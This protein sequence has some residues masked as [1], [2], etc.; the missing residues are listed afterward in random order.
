MTSSTQLDSTL[1]I[2]QKAV[3]LEEQAQFIDMEGKKETFSSFMKRSLQQIFLEHEL[4]VAEELKKQYHHYPLMSLDHR[5]ELIKSTR[6]LIFELSSKKKKKAGLIIQSHKNN[7]SNEQPIWEID[8]KWVPG[9]GEKV[10]LVLR[11]LGINTILDLI[12]YWPREHLNFSQR[13]PIKD[14]KVGSDATI[15]GIVKKVNAF[16]SPKNPN[17]SIVSTI[18]GDGSGTISLNRFIAGRSSKFLIEQYKKQMPL[19]ALIMAS[20]KVQFDRQTRFQLTNFSVQTLDENDQKESES[21]LE[22]GRIVSIYALTEGINQSRLRK[23]IYKSIERHLDSMEESLPEK[24]LNQNNL[25]ELKESIKQMHF[26]DSESVL[27]KAK[28]RIAFEE[29]WLAQMPLA[30]K[31]WENEQSKVSREKRTLLIS[32]DGPIN[33]LLASLPFELTGAQNRV[34][35]EI[36]HDLTLEKPMNRLVQGDVGSG[37]TIIALLTMLVAVERGKQA[38]MMAPTEILAEQHYKKFQ[39]LLLQIGVRV[40]LLI[41]SQKAAERREILT[42]LANGQIQ[43]VVGTHALIQDG[44]GFADLGLVVIDEQHRF[45]VRQRDFLRRKG[46]S[47]PNPL[48]RGNKE[49]KSPLTLTGKGVG[50]EVTNQIVD[51]LHM[52]ATPIPRTLTLALYGN[53][54]LSEIDEMPPGRKPIK[55]KIVESGN[56]PSVHEFIKKQ[57]REGRQAY[58]VFPLIEESETLSAKAVTEEAQKLRAI[59]KDF[60]LGIIHGRLDTTEKDSVMERFRKNEINILVGTTVIEVGVDVPNA[61]IMVIENAERFGLAQLHQLRGRVGRG[62]EQSYCIL[63]GNTK[64]PLTQQRLQIMEQTENGFVIAQKDLE[65]RG[66][67]ELLGTRQSGISDFALACLMQQGH[68]LEKARQAANEYVNEDPELKKLPEGTKYKLELLKEKTDLIEGG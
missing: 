20:G 17:L 22:V 15:V 29:F 10:S 11:K 39:Q 62:S 64:N 26:P 33:N 28:D 9:V 38:A 24:I 59:Y 45:G 6:K 12:T 25:L 2:I 52:T 57:L 51:C 68:L 23:I 41:G 37:K 31:R 61:S 58:I 40:G 67:G 18:V 14:L 43:I 5:I 34:F 47:P 60:E 42:G 65:L 3:E 44:V 27:E 19:G 7:A 54:D 50:G 46:L 32:E 8:V 13:L 49:T 1:Q 53:L 36:M 4:T 30:L 56:R 48:D 21:S 55:T 63:F 16:Q 66:P 35:N